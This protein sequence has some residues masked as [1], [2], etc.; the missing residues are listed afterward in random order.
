MTDDALYCWK[1]TM[2]PMKYRAACSS[3][4]HPLWTLYDHDP[5]CKKCETIGELCYACFGKHYDI[6]TES[7]D[8][9]SNAFTLEIT[10]KLKPRWPKKANQ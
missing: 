6:V 9:H 8:E 4:R 10:R 3:C 5:A 1:K 2:L 7:Q